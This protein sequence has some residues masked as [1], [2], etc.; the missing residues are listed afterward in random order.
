MKNCLIKVIYLKKQRKRM[1]L[2][3]K[4]LGEYVWSEKIYNITSEV[5][6]KKSL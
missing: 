6:D 2:Q 5:I 4:I 1:F 3:C